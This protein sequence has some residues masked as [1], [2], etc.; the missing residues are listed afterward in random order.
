MFL[1]FMA[2]TASWPW[3]TL[4]HKKDRGPPWQCWRDGAHQY[5]ISSSTHHTIVV[6]PYFDGT[7]S[8]VMQPWEIFWSG[9]SLL[10]EQQREHGHH[11]TDGQHRWG[12]HQRKILNIWAKSNSR[13]MHWSSLSACQQVH[14]TWITISSTLDKEIIYSWFYKIFV[15]SLLTC[16]T[17]YFHRPFLKVLQTST[18]NPSWLEAPV[19]Y[20]KEKRPLM[21]YHRST[22]AHGKAIQTIENPDGAR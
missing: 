7:L 8:Q 9:F 16:T 6:H 14:T 10:V 13:M 17:T 20:I 15:L 19:L 2:S 12:M 3:C 18:S 11:L 21:L 5:S 22:R 4:M 1:G